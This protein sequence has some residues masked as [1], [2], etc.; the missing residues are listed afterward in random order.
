M[1][2][3]RFALL[4]NVT[5]TMFRQVFPHLR[6]CVLPA[7]LLVL[8]AVLPILAALCLAQAAHTA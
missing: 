8:Q 7:A 3:R 2:Q 1:A 4:M 5:V 6:L